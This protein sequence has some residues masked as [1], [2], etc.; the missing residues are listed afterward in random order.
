MSTA[1][2]SLSEN[3]GSGASFTSSSFTPATGDL[4]VA[5]FQCG[6]SNSSAA[7]L[8]G[9]TGL[10]FTRLWTRTFGGA[11]TGYCFIA[12][13]SAS[14]S[15]QTV[16]LDISDDNATE[17]GLHLYLVTGQSVYGTSAV[18]QI[19]TNQSTTTPTLTMT[20]TPSTSNVLLGV[21]YSQDSALPICTE[22]SGWTEGAET[23]LGNNGLESCFVNG[24]YTTNPIAWQTNP[25]GGANN[26]YGI[27][28]IQATAS[29]PTWRA[30]IIIA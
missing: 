14:N 23:D 27:V 22:P 1:A 15:A 20:S 5:F 30:G 12:N 17:C 26:G 29:A 25:G 11:G 13:S 19:K 18:R 3:L 21:V 28:E 2:L 4:I 6:G 24:G 10:T 8:S 9:S 7:A 16:T